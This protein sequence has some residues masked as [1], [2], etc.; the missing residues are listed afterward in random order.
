[1]NPIE[2]I[3]EQSK[4]IAVV[5]L[6]SKPSRPSNEVAA[7]L[8]QQ[9]FK[10][11]PVNPNETQVLGEQA[12]PDLLAVPGPVDIVDVFRNPAAVPDV[13]EQAIKKNAKVVWMQPGAENYDAADKAKAAGLK[14]IVGMCL[15][16][17]HRLYR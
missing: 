17:Q 3:I 13:V 5:G 10:I 1:M 14:A 16:V 7:Y 9:G 4:T 6:S 15:R 12:Y 8:Q 2:E 11:I